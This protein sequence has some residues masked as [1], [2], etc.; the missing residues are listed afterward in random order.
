MADLSSKTQRADTNADVPQN[1][2]K[3][4]FKI[5]DDFPDESSF[6]AHARKVFYNDVQADKTNR[7]AA[8]ED[9]QF[10]I[11]KQWLDWIEAMRTAAKKPVITVNRLPA[12]VAQILGN[13]RLNETQIKVVP[14]NGG[15]QPIAA[16]REGLIR[17]IQKNT[18]AETVYNNAH[19][20]QVICGVG[21]FQVA[22]EYAADDVFEQDIKIKPIPNALGVVWDRMAIEPTGRDA[23]HCFVVDN[24]A[25]DD[26][27]LQWPW[28]QA[29]DMTVDTGLIGELRTQGWVRVDDV[30]VATYWRMRKE[31]RTLA[32]MQDGKVIDVTDKPVE[33]YAF[34]VVQRADGSPVIREADHKYAE[35][36]TI[37]GTDILEGPYRLDISRV[38]VLRVP[39]WEVNVGEERHRWGL[40]RFMKDPQR[41]HNYWRSVIAEKLMQTPRGVW[42]ARASAVQ[43]REKEWRESHLKDDPLLI[44]NDDAAEAPTR[45]P[46]AQLEQALI[47]EAGMATQ[48]LR[49][50]SNLHEASMGQ[51]S[52]EVSGKA[53]VARQRVGELGS[54]IY[55]DN[56]NLAIAEAGRIIDE[57]IPAV[58][59]TPRMVCIT[60]T[61]DKEAL[62]AIND[63]S[64]TGTDISTGKYKI[65]ITN[66]P[67]FVTRRAEAAD[68]MATFIN[69]VPQAAPLVMDIVV[70]AQDW[71]MADQ[72]AARLKH[73][74]PPQALEQDDMT[75][76]MKQQQQQEAQAQQ[77]AAQL[78]QA[79]AQ[80]T[81]RKAVAEAEEAEA[82]VE[83]VRAQTVK[84]QTDPIIKTAAEHSKSAHLHFEDQMYAAE[85]THGKEPPDGERDAGKK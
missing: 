49:D 59:D 3:P 16:L 41:L 57:L 7:E 26:F 22:L 20:N 68:A 15:T 32:L 55:Q 46:P 79:M 62:V 28:A 74:V 63:P 76:E 31:K 83:L 66:G 47:T 80:V 12:F 21:N 43:G 11:G 77:G 35:M 54:V 51:Q 6:L 23:T 25:N 53:I 70:Q 78:A 42:I 45:T 2:T 52:N 73:G 64:N 82:R 14:D 60:G 44:F 18:S 61:D 5:P 39:G 19:Q 58:Y 48:D 27:K 40:V 10:F 17:N 24:I 36:Y 34:G 8:V 81:L 84:T 37:S 38:P 71:P 9:S 1:Y 69:A 75:P 4:K 29:A 67:S 33:Q 85:F 13:R 30:R 50:V 65:T 56:L 72:F